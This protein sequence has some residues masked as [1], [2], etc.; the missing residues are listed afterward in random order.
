MPRDGLKSP[1][2]ALENPVTILRCFTINSP[3]LSC[4]FGYDEGVFG[5]AHV[6]GEKVILVRRVD[7]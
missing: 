1:R 2:I 6:V 5:N 4:S 7:C 3:L